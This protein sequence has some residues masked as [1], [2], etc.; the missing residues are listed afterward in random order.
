MPGGTMWVAVF[1]GPRFPFQSSEKTFPQLQ[2]L[3]A[4]CHEV[5]AH[6]AKGVE[7]QILVR[8]ADEE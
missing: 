4:H 2:T 8:K 6:F 3:S 1:N 7:P 5:P